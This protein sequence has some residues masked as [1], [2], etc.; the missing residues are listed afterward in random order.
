MLVE[1]MQNSHNKSLSIWHKNHSFLKTVIWKETSSKLKLRGT[2]CL[3][4]EFKHRRLWWVESSVWDGGAETRSAWGNFSRHY[5]RYVK[6]WTGVPS[7]EEFKEQ[8]LFLLNKFLSLQCL[9]LQRLLQLILLLWKL[10]EKRENTRVKKNKKG[11]KVMGK[12]KI[13]F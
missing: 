10:A 8:L 6:R 3:T 12:Y 7:M 1:Y 4:L 5:G 11:E 13:I 2:G 9:L